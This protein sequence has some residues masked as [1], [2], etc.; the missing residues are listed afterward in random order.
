[1]L[2]FMYESSTERKGVTILGGRGVKYVE[3]RVLKGG[4]QIAIFAL[5]G[6]ALLAGFVLTVV[7]KITLHHGGNWLLPLGGAFALLVIVVLASLPWWRW[8]I[9][10][11]ARRDYKNTSISD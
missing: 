10:H 1:M 6:I 2:N 11:Q 3:R 4:W 7:A 5:A 8:K 9:Q